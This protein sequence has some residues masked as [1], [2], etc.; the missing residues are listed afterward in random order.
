MDFSKGIL[1]TTKRPNDTLTVGDYTI[2]ATN[3]YTNGLKVETINGSAALKVGNYKEI[4]AVERKDKKPF[5]L[6]KTI[7]FAGG[8]LPIKSG[9]KIITAN[10]IVDVPA[11]AA[12]STVSIDED[13]NNI[14][15]FQ[16][17]FSDCAP[18]VLD[19]DIGEIVIP[20]SVIRSFVADDVKTD[21]VVRCAR[22][23]A[24]DNSCIRTW[25]SLEP[26]LSAL[27]KYGSKYDKIIRVNDFESKGMQNL[28]TLTP[29]EGSVFT[30]PTD[31]N[32]IRDLAK[33][34]VD[35]LESLGLSKKVK[36][37]LFNEPD[38]GAYWPNKDWKGCFKFAKEYAQPFRDRGWKVCGPSMARLNFTVVK[39]V[40]AYM[41]S[42]DAVNSFDAIDYHMYSSNAG[43]TE[44]CLKELKT[45]VDSYN[46]QF[47]ISECGPG[48]K[49]GED[50]AK[51]T[52]AV[53]PLFEK[54][55]DLYTY[56]M[57][58]YNTKFPTHSHLYTAQGVATSLLPAYKK[59][60]S[61]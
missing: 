46:L 12:G 43:Y 4:L 40:I 28:I 54:Y 45:F 29:S 37:Q 16:I 7:F 50:Y 53:V 49:P 34:V 26:N 21:I 51:S 55:C 8:N 48:Q 18:T 6:L 22:E 44:N 35:Q 17:K 41:K 58:T 11:T 47:W 56:W 36:L 24:G 42:I 59:G 9:C 3:P 19:I 2:I 60:I 5:N 25:Q 10:K 38:S 52:E 23:A 1:S 20:S 13:I 27:K 61:K 32:V 33:K 31:K 39:E 15:S 57:L 14:T 30:V